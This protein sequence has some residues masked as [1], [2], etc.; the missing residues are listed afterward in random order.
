MHKV[1]HHPSIPSNYL[2]FQ[3][4]IPPGIDPTVVLE[5]EVVTEDGNI[6]NLAD[7]EENSMYNINFNIG[8]VDANSTLEARAN[9]YQC[10]NGKN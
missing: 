4:I 7:D 5:S 10:L 6:I 2:T 3:K 8:F 1:F 9:K